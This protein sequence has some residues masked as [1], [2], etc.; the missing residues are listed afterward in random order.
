MGVADVCRMPAPLG[1]GA[2]SAPGAL[3]LTAW[4]PAPLPQARTVL[5]ELAP[6]FLLLALN[7]CLLLQLSF[8]NHLGMEAVEHH[9]RL[10]LFQVIYGRHRVPK[11]FATFYAPAKKVAEPSRACSHC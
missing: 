7:H 11:P 8:N 10:G 4:S 2:H 9:E 1:Q 5:A 6:T 3:Q